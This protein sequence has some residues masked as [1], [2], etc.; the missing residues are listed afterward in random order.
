MS[1]V[2][3]RNSI[4]A[5]IAQNL[6]I[7]YSGLFISTRKLSLALQMRIPPDDCPAIRKIMRTTIRVF[8]VHT[9]TA[10]QCSVGEI[11]TLNEKISR[12]MEQVEKIMTGMYTSDQRIYSMM[13]RCCVIE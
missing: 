5:H 13:K 1:L 12:I 9:I 4:D 6:N 10:S 7:H 3:K 11:F 2:I 8:E